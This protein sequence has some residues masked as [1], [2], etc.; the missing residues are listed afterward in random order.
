LYLIVRSSMIVE[1]LLDYRL[2]LTR[3]RQIYRR[4]PD[5]A[6]AVR[7]GKELRGIVDEMEGGAHWAHLD[8]LALQCVR[9][10]QELAGPV[11]TDDSAKV[12][13]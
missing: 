6:E 3:W 10:M 4:M 9:R 13:R 5:Q 12:P 1:C 2:A 8:S 7:L 11:W